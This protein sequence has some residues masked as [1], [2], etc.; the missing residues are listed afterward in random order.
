MTCPEN[1]V[2]T[3]DLS[4]RSSI[5]L[6]QRVRGSTRKYFLL[7]NKGIVGPLSAY[8]CEPSGGKVF[9]CP[10]TDPEICTSAL[11]PCSLFADFH[12]S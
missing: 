5:R 2:L 6:S 9:V 8:I 11:L 3:S 12:M 10:I 7:L 4:G 1:D